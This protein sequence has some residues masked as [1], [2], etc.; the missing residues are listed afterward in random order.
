M[1]DRYR[2]RSQEA[3]Q[4]YR[5]C[6]EW[7]TAKGRELEAKGQ[8]EEVEGEGLEMGPGGGYVYSSPNGREWAKVRMSLGR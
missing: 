6:W 4:A 1:C 5:K 7:L 8:E 2:H 3:A